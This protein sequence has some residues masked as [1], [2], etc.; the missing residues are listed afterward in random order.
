MLGGRW[1]EHGVSR[2]T[3]ALN[4]VTVGP[5]DQLRKEDGVEGL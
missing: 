3:S 4:G 1:V 5:R 2:R